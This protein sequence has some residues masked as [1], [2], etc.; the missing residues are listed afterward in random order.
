[1][2]S[3]D[4][5]CG[6]I[7]VYEV[8]AMHFFCCMILLLLSVRERDCGGMR[9][10]FCVIDCLERSRVLIHFLRPMMH[11]VTCSSRDIEFSEGA[12]VM[13]CYSKFCG[14]CVSEYVSVIRESGVHEL[15]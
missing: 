15:L 1:M 11:R 10:T 12:C 4:S 13:E 9:L 14:V 6:F 2:L 5:L 7:F 8:E 3:S